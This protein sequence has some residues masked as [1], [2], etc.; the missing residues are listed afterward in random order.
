MD[1][2]SANRIIEQYFK[3]IYGYS[4]KKCFS[5]DEA[6]E[7]CAAIGAQLWAALLK[8]DTLTNPDGFVWQVCEHVYSK[9]LRAKLKPGGD[10][11]R[12][13]IYEADYPF[14]DDFSAAEQCEEYDR[15]R[16]EIAFL[17]KTR[18]EIV[19]LHYFERVS[20]AEISRRLSPSC[21]NGKMALKQS[22]RRTKKGLHHGKKNRQ[23][24]IKPFTFNKMHLRS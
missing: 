17:T 16:V 11:R 22:Q 7:L 8:T 14:Q 2:Q 4:I 21:R 5:Y 9:H 13:S 6:E 12:V 15:L 24:W 19:Y 3:K 1:K 10:G 23:A 20:I 18:R